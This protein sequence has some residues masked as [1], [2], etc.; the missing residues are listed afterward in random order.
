MRPARDDIW[1]RRQAQGLFPAASLLSDYFMKVTGGEQQSAK[2]ALELVDM[3]ETS[4]ANCSCSTNSANI[5][6][7]VRGKCG[8]QVWWSGRLVDHRQQKED[9][10]CQRRLIGPRVS[11]VHGEIEKDILSLA[12]GSVRLCSLYDLMANTERLFGRRQQWK[13]TR[14]HSFSASLNRLLTNNNK[15]CV[16]LL[17]RLLLLFLKLLWH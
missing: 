8:W 1:A 14:L 16:C 15:A 6:V 7:A 4:A 13:S 17:P 10:L 11:H 2:C 9:L 3:S 12:E 5:T